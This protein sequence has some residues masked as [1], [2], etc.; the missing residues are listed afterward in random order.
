MGGALSMAG[1]FE[2][3]RLD[4]AQGSLG[5]RALGTWA[6]LSI[7]RGRAPVSPALVWGV[8]AHADVDLV[9]QDLHLVSAGLRPALCDLSDLSESE[10]TVFSE[11]DLPTFSEGDLTAFPEGD[12]MGFLFQPAGFGLAKC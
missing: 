2:M 5:S 3:C 8:A 6:T 7:E 1:D 12:L 4:Q 11:G 9:F 10:L